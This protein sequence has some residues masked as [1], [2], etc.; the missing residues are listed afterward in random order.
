MKFAGYE[1]G[2]HNMTQDP[3]SHFILSYRILWIIEYNNLLFPYFVL[4]IHDI[5]VSINK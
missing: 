5:N 2:G 4:K 1:G 3:L